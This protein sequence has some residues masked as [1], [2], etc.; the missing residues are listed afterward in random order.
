MKA[1]IT[2]IRMA[3]VVIG[4]FA[5]AAMV[6]LP[7]TQIFLR[8]VGAPIVGLEELSRY[9]MIV[10]TF[11]GIPLVTAEGG[12]I[13]M[14]E[15]QRLLPI[16]AAGALRVIIAV[17]SGAAFATVVLAIWLSLEITIGSSTPTLGIPFWLFNLPAVIGLA[18]GAVEFWAQAWRTMRGRD[19]AAPLRLA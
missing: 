6:V 14:D 5:L 12:Q 16:T 18:V 1:A 4:C 17:V 9:F 3:C 10:I 11:I 13:R 19:D 2:F 15:I 7:T 8:F